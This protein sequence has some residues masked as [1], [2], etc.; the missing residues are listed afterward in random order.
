MNAPND[1]LFQM[2]FN[3][4]SEP[5]IVIK[6]DAPRYTIVACNELYK[7]VSNTVGQDLIGKGI[8]DLT[9]SSRS[10]KESEAVIQQA[11][12]RAIR[13]NEVVKLAAVRYDMPSA[14]GQATE[15][16]WWQTEY[17]PIVGADGHVQYL[18]CTTHNITHHIL[19]NEVKKAATE[20]ADALTREQ[21]TNEELTAVNEELALANQELYHAQETLRKLN[22]DLEERIKSRTKELSESEVRFRAMAEGTDVL[23][24][25][26]DITRNTVYCNKAWIT[27]TGQPRQDLLGFGWIKVVHPDDME[28]HLNSCLSAFKER[29]PYTDEIRIVNHQGSYRWLLAKG[30]PLFDSNDNFTGYISSFIDIHERKQDEQRKNDFIGMVSHELKTPLTSLNGY[31]QMLLA[32]AN[33]AEDTFTAGALTKAVNQ[34]KKMTALINGFLNVSRLESGKIQVNKQTFLMDELVKEMTEEAALIQSTHKIVFLPCNPVSV[35]ADRDKIGSVISNLLSNAIKYSPRGKQIEVKCEEMGNEVQVSVKDEGMGIKPENVEKLF[36][37][38]YRIESKHTQNI[39]GFGI[40]LYL[41][42]EIVQRHN[43]KIW[44]E[45][46]IGKGSTFYFSLPLQG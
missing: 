28:R 32:K 4:L 12:E 22:E 43:G 40:G 35:L 26:S 8:K 14:N 27:L 19:I 6:A 24:A 41:C 5:R 21:M 3:H 13:N 39:S 10:S 1:T 11:I 34:I 29:L 18:M 2:L 45:S 9:D 44:V 42:A 30:T 20:R 16:A 36:D 46:Q 25:V 7:M 33:K 23:I 37:R 31:I 38:Y 17:V 15:A